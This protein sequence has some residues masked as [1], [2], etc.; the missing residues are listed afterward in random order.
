M[1]KDILVA[2]LLFTLIIS[3]RAY[4][5]EFDELDKPPE[6]AHKGQMLLGGFVC[7]G[8]PM[9]DLVDAED[10]FLED[11]VYTFDNEVTKSIEVSHQ[12]FAFGISFEYMPLDHIGSITRLRKT[13]I[14]QRSNFGSAYQNWRGYIYRDT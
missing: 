11:S 13:Y 6:G 7:I 12:S 8:V 3:N 10:D 1:A 9:G 2:V 14:V 4:S 5:T